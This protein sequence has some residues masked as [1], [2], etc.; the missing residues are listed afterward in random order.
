MKEKLVKQYK[1]DYCGKKQLRKHTM[2]IH[3]TYCTLNPNRSC[4]MC[5]ILTGVDTPPKISFKLP[6]PD[7]QNISDFGTNLTN[8]GVLDNALI[9]LREATDNCPACI[10]SAIRKTGSH[11]SEY[12]FDFKEECN[13]FFRENQKEVPDEDYRIY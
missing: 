3:E 11:T 6:V 2:V 1:C 8:K 9:Q 12:G 13:R 4:R 7:Y 10:L 5:L